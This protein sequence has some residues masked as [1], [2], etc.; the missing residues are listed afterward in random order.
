MFTHMFPIYMDI[1]VEVTT[2]RLPPPR[3]GAG[4]SAGASLVRGRAAAGLDLAGRP[5]KPQIAVS[6][7]WEITGKSTGNQWNPVGNE[8][9]NLVVKIV[10]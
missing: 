6:T 7:Q 4:S 10:F 8:W 2:G 9:C 1:C 5:G 3:V